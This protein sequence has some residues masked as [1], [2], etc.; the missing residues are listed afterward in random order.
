MKEDDNTWMYV[1]TPL[2][3]AF[4]KTNKQQNKTK[5]KQNKNKKQKQYVHKIILLQTKF[6]FQ[7]SKYNMVQFLVIF[8]TPILSYV[9]RS[10]KPAT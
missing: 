6:G 2:A 5:Q 4:T 8:W 10:G 1:S 9:M 3:D 7:Y